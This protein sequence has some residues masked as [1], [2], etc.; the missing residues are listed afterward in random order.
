MMASSL[1]R[2]GPDRLRATAQGLQVW[3]A[4]NGYESLEQANGSFSQQAVGDP[5]AFERSNYVRTL[6]SYSPEW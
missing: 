6:I 4:S 2:N 1:L 5:S 3:L